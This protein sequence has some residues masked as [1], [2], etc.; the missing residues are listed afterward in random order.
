MLTF[1]SQRCYTAFMKVN[2][3][4][5]NHKLASTCLDRYG[6]MIVLLTLDINE[7]FLYIIKT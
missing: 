5:A 6:R 7:P 3:V 4:Q 1:A 2:H